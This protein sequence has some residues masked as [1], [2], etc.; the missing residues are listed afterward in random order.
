VKKRENIHR[1][2]CLFYSN[3]RVHFAYTEVN[4]NTLQAAEIKLHGFMAPLVAKAAYPAEMKK[5]KPAF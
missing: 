4:S 5:R 3:I 2:A 1:M